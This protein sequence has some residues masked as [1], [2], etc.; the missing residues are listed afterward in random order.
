VVRLG[1]KSITA[2]TAMISVAMSN[3]IEAGSII[4][5]ATSLSLWQKEFGIDDFAVGLLAAL[6]ANA[7][8]AAAGALLG[9]PLCDKYGRKFIYTYD[10][11]L[12]MIGVALAV[13]AGSYWMLLVAFIIT[14]IAVGA[15]VPAS[16]TYLS[17]QA[18]AGERAKHVGA[19][20]LA[21]SF[22]PLIGFLLAVLVEPLGLLG[23]R[24]IFAQLFVVAFI[25]WYMR[26]GLPETEIWKES[27]AASTS[28]SL[29]HGVR[30]LFS[31]K[32]N[33]T[34]IFFLIGVYSFW[35]I[36]AGQAGIFMPRVYAAAG[37]ESAT[38]QYLLQA[39][40]WGLTVVTT[41]FGFMKLA[42]KYNRRILYIVGSLLGIA[43]WAVLVFAE[44]TMPALL[45]FAVLWGV[46]AGIGAQAFYGLWASELFATQ[47]RASAQG[48]LF[49]V[50]RIMVGLLSM[51]FPILLTS[52]GLS[53]LGIILIGFLTVSLVVGAVWAPR[54]QGKSLQAIERER[55]PEEFQAD[56]LA[57]APGT[58]REPVRTR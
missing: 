32:A 33:I 1:K 40:V 36:V 23:S 25:T 11:I 6:S 20:Q 53:W 24:L 44:P 54:T 47:Y 52:I 19:A 14:G 9:G 8:G 28:T 26:Q 22:G 15:G 34:A 38:E 2:R 5:I 21:W 43:A 37:V 50:A 27:N 10:L 57:G 3:Y 39:L 56:T 46:A 7:F 45:S 41:Y 4:A 29:M 49:F 31:K 58:T 12:Y 17:E 35:N 18:P 42:D 30:Q 51:V 16:W 13:F 48:I 55:Y